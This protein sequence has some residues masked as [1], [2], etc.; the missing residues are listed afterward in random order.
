MV[1]MARYNVGSTETSLCVQGQDRMGGNANFFWLRCEY[2]AGAEFP[3]AKAQSV[4][5]VIYRVNSLGVIE[6]WF[7]CGLT[8]T[9]TV[10]VHQMH[11]EH[12]ITSAKNEAV[13][14]HTKATIA[15]F[16]SGVVI[17]CLRSICSIYICLEG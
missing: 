2:L 10:S 9:G 1:L 17:R 6:A 12:Q 16:C 15:G 4:R 7:A 11:A 5:G 13:E 14:P 3:I 8:G